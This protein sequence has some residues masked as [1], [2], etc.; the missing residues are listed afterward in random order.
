MKREDITRLFE[1]ATEEQIKAV[2]DANS[3]ISPTH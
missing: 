2:L 3:A 1:G